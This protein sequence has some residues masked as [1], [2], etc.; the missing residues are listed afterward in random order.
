MK[1]LHII[2]NVSVIMQP[3]FCVETCFTELQPCGKPPIIKSTIEYTRA[4]IS[5][6]LQQTCLIVNPMRNGFL[7]LLTM[8]HVHADSPM[9]FKVH[10]RNQC[11][12]HDVMHAQ[13]STCTSTHTPRINKRLNISVSVL[14]FF[15]D[16]RREN[17]GT[18][19]V[20]CLTSTLKKSSIED[21][22]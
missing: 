2:G 9:I 1:Q 15:C 19:C 14:P 20:N 11:N 12:A 13:L 8:L 17:K 18:R 4:L 21:K 10:V 3:L 6:S 22:H 7:I 16:A 5:M